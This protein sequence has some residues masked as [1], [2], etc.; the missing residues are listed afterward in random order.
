M[1]QPD[2]QQSLTFAVAGMSCASCVARVEKA[3]QGV[4]GVSAASV[5]F[6]TELASVAGT[7]LSPVLLEQAVAAAGY[8]ARLQQQENAS[9]TKSAADH[10]GLLEVLLAGLLTLPLLLPMLLAWFGTHV[11]LDG[12]LQFGLATPVQFWFGRRFYHGA[13]QA[14][15][16]GTSNMDTLVVLGT[17]AAWGLSTFMLLS[18]QA[19]MD[20]LYFE[21]SAVLVTLILLGK[22]LEARAKHQTTE[23]LRALQ[24]LHPD[25]ARILHEGT[26]REVPLAQ[27]RK[28][29]QVLIRPGERVPAD[30]LILQGSSTLD[31]ALLTG[32]SLPVSRETGARVIGGS[33]NL[34]A[35]LT[36]EVTAIGAETTLARIIR[37]VTTAQQNKAPIQRLVDRVSAVFVPV[38]LVLATL[39]LLLWGLLGNDWPQALLNAVAVLVI[40]CPCALGLATPTAIMAGTGVAARHGI[41]IRDALALE[42]AQALSIVAFDK[43]GTLTEGRPR[44]VRTVTLK[45]G[46]Q[47]PPDQ[48]NAEPDGTEPEGTVTGPVPPS[49]QGMI[50]EVQVG[51]TTMQGEE[52][53]LLALLAGIQQG[54]THPL[55]RAVLDAA[56]SAALKVLPAQDIKAL[57]GRGMV[58]D[59][60]GRQVW[61]GNQRLMEELGIPSAQLA[62]LASLHGSGGYTL[63]WA[64]QRKTAQ[65]DADAHVQLLGLLLFQDTV[66]PS[67]RA[68][69]ARLHEMGLRTLMLTG[70]NLASAQLIATDIGL[71]SIRAEVLPEHKAA[72][73]AEL[74][75]EGARVA[76]VGDGINDA[77]ALATADV[78]IAMGSGTDVAMQTAGIT[79]MQGDPLRVADAITISRLT[80]RKIRQNLFWAFVYNVLGLPLAAFGLLNPMLAGA[81]MA[82]SSVCV[83]GN[84][85]LLRYWHPTKL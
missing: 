35:L 51:T 56:S 36:V 71:D 18:G 37:L 54:S 12:W 30:G 21:A 48:P 61:F 41:L 10:K 68:A 66:K 44:V 81:A 57:P 38:V 65:Q 20:T 83:V 4:P 13:W 75:Q 52:N 27:L 59:C 32:E 45:P 2:R 78:G 24:A 50:R 15:R 53:A 23:A 7:G 31:E 73:I 26:A 63:S 77:P 84:A 42:A 17:S 9:Q 55:A 62:G 85:L 43:T 39:T 3:L 70:D 34:E 33:I 60:D 11:M 29:D 47:N 19:G 64:A 28:G 6:A 5:N 74:Q 58:A 25:T 1:H 14:L 79:L 72:V 49:R 69:I 40:A 8:Q 76:M 22:W 67:A 80:Y 82:F 16:A 46:L